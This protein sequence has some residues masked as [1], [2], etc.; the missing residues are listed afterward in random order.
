MKQW[1]FINLTSEIFSEGGGWMELALDGV[2]WR[3]LV[4]VSNFL[5]VVPVSAGWNISLNATLGSCTAQ[6]SRA[7]TFHTLS[8]AKCDQPS[9][10]LVAA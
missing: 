5:V 3:I 7:S 10:L 4:A 6:S 1:S 8:W 2:Q 9:L